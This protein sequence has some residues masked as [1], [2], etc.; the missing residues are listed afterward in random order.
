MQKE[1]DEQNIFDK[2]LLSLIEYA[3]WE[4]YNFNLLKKSSKPVKSELLLIDRDT[5]K[6]WK[7]ISGYNIFKK[8]IF[9]YL[10][11]LNKIKNFKDKIK[12]EKENINKKWQNIF[13][14]KKIEHKNNNS[15]PFKD[16]SGLYLNIKDKKI[17]AYKNYEVI[18]SKLFN[19][20]KKFINIKIIV[21]GI[22]NNRKLIIPINY[23]K[24]KNLNQSMKTGENFLEIV[25]HNN[26]NEIEDMLCILPDDN[27]A[28]K[29]IED[30]Y[31]NESIDNLK[32][33][34]SKTN[35]E[36]NQSI[37]DFIDINGNKVPIQIIN[38]KYTKKTQDN[39]YKSNNEKNN[40]I[41]LGKLKLILSEKMNI[42]QE[43]NKRINQRNNN[44]IKL[45]SN[46]I[47]KNREEHNQKLEGIKNDY[48]RYEKEYTNIKYKLELKKKSLND[49]EKKIQNLVFENNAEGEEKFGSV[50]YSGNNEIK[51]ELI[52]D[53]NNNYLIKEKKL[54]EN[55]NY[56]NKRENELNRKENDLRKKELEVNDE[57]QNLLNKEKELIKKLN[58][59]NEQ[60][61]INKNKSYL[62][63]IKE[64]K[65]DNNSQD[66][67]INKE[68]DK[69]EEEFEKELDSSNSSN[70]CKIKKINI[71]KKISNDYKTI[72]STSLTHRNPT[73]VNKSPENIK[74]KRTTTLTQNFKN[75]SHNEYMNSERK[76]LPFNIKRNI[77]FNEN[78]ISP[79]KS[80]NTQLKRN[81]KINQKE[82]KINKNITSLGLE[83]TDHPININAVLQCLAH[84]PEL[85]EGILEL[86]YK[87]KYF[88]ENK[89][90]ELSRNFASIVNNLFFPEKYNNSSKIYSPKNFVETFLNMYPLKNYE[91]PVIYLNMNEML[92]FILETFHKE[93]NI[94]KKNNIKEN[95]DSKEE[96]KIE[97]S[98]EKEVL[99]K[100]LTKFTENNNSLISKLFYGLTKFK[101]V[102][103]K[104]GSTKYDFDYYNHLYFDLHKIKEYMMNNKF[105]SKN[106]GFF[107]INDC[108]D[109][110]RRDINLQV[111][112][113]EINLSILEKFKI[114][115]KSGKSICDKCQKETKC[116]LYNYL[117]SANTILPIILDRGN[118]DNFLIEEIIIP[119][120]LNLE[121]YVEY[122]KSV[123]KYY[124][125]G[126]VS[127][128]GKTNLSA[129]ELI[130]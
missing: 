89:N 76:S 37:T 95:I 127:N 107:S 42:L 90:V 71:Q 55:E 59:I 63:K 4:L 115:K 87:E 57:K 130:I 84:I 11:T 100:F 21:N 54:K 1:N 114:N 47:N 88:K 27:D 36:N 14:E 85:E 49:K 10:F 73:K 125:C 30:Y 120:E 69:L 86:G 129:P 25:Y 16:L 111:F 118:D 126:V 23:E 58:E 75:I 92:K 17:N 79:T 53:S 105:K 66:N 2:D 80:N 35:N 38:K 26:K 108:L 48:L 121:N 56:L 32:D 33:I 60:L 117:Y 122:N 101:C 52:L 96:N 3:K 12:Q 68:L 94:K 81:N 67:N 5:L 41:E 44:I 78:L 124:L 9:S 31:S 65:E 34:F 50:V 7:E 64:E 98:N 18:S 13:K 62:M 113:K 19:L 72:N 46:D 51:S 39:S 74:Y 22:Y 103:D 6:K 43:V 83:E 29:Q 91:T 82:T 15:I 119:E 109:Y 102:C 40:G 123:K 28:C 77:T 70:K 99:V 20:F 106:V 110:Q 93:L 61:I 112:F 45:K 24:E 97:L 104:C 116:S 8:Q 128:L